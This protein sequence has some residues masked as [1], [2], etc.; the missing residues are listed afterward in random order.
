ML[1]TSKPQTARLTSVR[2]KAAEITGKL[3]VSKEQSFTFVSPYCH[4]QTNYVV[5][6]NNDDDSNSEPKG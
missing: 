5:T 4:G 3:L 6:K 2:E 1:L